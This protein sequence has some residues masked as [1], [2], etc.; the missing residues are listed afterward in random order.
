[1]VNYRDFNVLM[2]INDDCVF[3]SYFLLFGNC[4]DGSSVNGVQSDDPR[5]RP[6]PAKVKNA[7]TIGKY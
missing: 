5:I 1:M 4:A 2:N 7:T 3:E 6:S